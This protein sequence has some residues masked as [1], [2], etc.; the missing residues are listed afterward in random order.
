AGVPE[1][2]FTVQ[3]ADS[4]TS[5]LGE[6]TGSIAVAQDGQTVPITVS[7]VQAGLGVLGFTGERDL[8]VFSATAGDSLTV[9]EDKIANGG[10]PPLPDPFVEIFNPD[11]TF[12][13][14]NDDSGGNLNSLFTGTALQSGQHVI[15]A[16]AY[17]DAY[18]GGYR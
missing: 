18:T 10:F 9:H 15:A 14:S 8:W 5:T 17:A 16:R 6:A 11:G 3:A 1:G 13:G 2:T 4:A 7:L 12:R